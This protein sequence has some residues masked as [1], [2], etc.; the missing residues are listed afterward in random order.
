MEQARNAESYKLEG[1]EAFKQQKYEKAVVLY[2]RAITRSNGKY[3]TYFTNR[4]LCKLKMGPE[5]T[6]SVVDDCVKALDLQVQHD[7]ISMKA[8][9]YM[10]QAQLL[11]L[12]PNEAYSSLAKAYRIATRFPN[13]TV[14][15]IQAKMLEARKLRWEILE[16]RRIEQEGTLGAQLLGLIQDQKQRQL[17]AARDNPFATK[18]IEEKTDDT[19]RSLEDLLQRSDERFRIREVPDYLCCPISM[20]LFIDPVITPNGKSYERTSIIQHL[21]TTPYDPLTRNPLKMSQLVP[22]LA[23][24]DASEDFLSRN[25]WAAD[26]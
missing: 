1:N 4:A 6:E 18:E 21:M 9:Y 13:N 26:Y 11:M 12:R 10:G 5:H 23:L 19:I 16:R 24:R 8:Y 22:N 2:S 25:G 7:A 15:D 14:L 3:P 17:H 20:S